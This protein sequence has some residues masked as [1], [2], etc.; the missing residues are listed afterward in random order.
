MRK[1]I[2]SMMMSLD[3]F[4]A[5]PNDEMDWLPPFNDEALWKD[6]HKQMWEHLRSVDT[7]LLGRATYQ[8][9]ESYW[10]AAATNPASTKNDLEFSRYADETQKLVFSTTLKN[11]DWK[12]T[13]LVKENIA[14][15]I[16]NLKKQP[17]KN[18][19]VAGGAGIAQTFIRLGLID[20]YHL[21]VHPVI[22]GSGKPLFKGS[23]SRIRLKLVGTQ[24]LRP[25]VV[26]L[27]YRPL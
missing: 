1:V 15:E 22:L 2:L 21:L 13:R 20:E 5:G 7:L 3:G 18:L 23:E 17:G 26:A 14:E 6:I 9:W 25:E 8:I 12:N 10:P 19:A 4:V 11:A 27:H 16:S 24:T